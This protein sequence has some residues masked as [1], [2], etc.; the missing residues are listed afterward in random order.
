MATEQEHLM[1]IIT[2]WPLFWLFVVAICIGLGAYSLLV[3]TG[4]FDDNR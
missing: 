4:Y 2:G 1:V 3:M